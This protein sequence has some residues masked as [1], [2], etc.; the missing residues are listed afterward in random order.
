MKTIRITGA[1]SGIGL[2]TANQLHLNGIKV[3]GTSRTPEKF[4]NRFPF[5]LVELD[6]TSEA[7][8]ARCVDTVLSASKTIDALINNAGIAVCG[9]A[10]ETSLEQAYRQVETNFW[11]AVKMTRE[12]LPVMRRQ[13]SG[14]I[15]TIGS[16]AGLMGVPFQSYYSASKHALEGYFKSL[17]IEVRTFNIKVS[18][19]EP[20]FFRTNLHN[21]FEFAEGTN[22]DYDRIRKNTLQ[23]FSNSIEKA[24]NPDL[25]AQVVLKI[26]NSK[27][28][29]FSYRIGKNSWIAPNLQFLWYNL[30]EFGLRSTFK[31]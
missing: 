23:V 21:S 14:T 15:I 9:S 6:I 7:S 13:R 17:R 28:P 11:G 31:L 5:E 18:M 2:F 19:V 27:N 24:D 16:L 25:V 3:F 29:G 8:V 20:G 30:F 12:M 10:E 4:S 26:L 22:E 1:T